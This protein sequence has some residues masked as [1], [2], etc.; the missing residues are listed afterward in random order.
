[1]SEGT[2]LRSHKALWHQSGL[3]LKDVPQMSS[4]KTISLYTERD[5]GAILLMSLLRA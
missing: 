4:R 2:W 1:V 5:A 3:I